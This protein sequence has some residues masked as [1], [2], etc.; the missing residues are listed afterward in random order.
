[1]GLYH[2]CI[3]RP[4]SSDIKPGIVY[5]DMPCHD[6]KTE[7]ENYEFKYVEEREVCM[8][9]G[10]V[11]SHMVASHTAGPGIVQYGHEIP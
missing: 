6:T 9:I 7:R 11:S 4:V 5:H 3:L 2:R 1:M 8:I 10:P